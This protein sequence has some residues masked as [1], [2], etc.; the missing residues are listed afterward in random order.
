MV[1]IP[2]EPSLFIISSLVLFIFGLGNIPH[3][4]LQVM[5]WWNYCGVFFCVI[6]WNFIWYLCNSFKCQFSSWWVTW[7]IIGKLCRYSI[8]KVFFFFCYLIPHFYF[9]LY[10]PHWVSIGCVYIPAPEQYILHD[11]PRPLPQF[12]PKC[13]STMN[14][15]LGQP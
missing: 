6:Y 11:S 3:P 8:L 4:L 2:R 15:M 10:I 12:H 13:P 14:S 1:L 7:L 9:F 5:N